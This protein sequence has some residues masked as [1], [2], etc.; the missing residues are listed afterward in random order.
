[1]LHTWDTSLK[2]TSLLCGT[3]QLP[4][5]VDFSSHVDSLT[6]VHALPSSHH[7]LCSGCQRLPVELEP[8]LLLLLSR[9]SRVRLCATP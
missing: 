2:I 5:P 1:M 9:F 4:D 8:L 3:N 6:P 7:C